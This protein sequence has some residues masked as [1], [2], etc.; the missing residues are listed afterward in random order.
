[1]FYYYYG[2][3]ALDTGLVNL[4]DLSWFMFRVI[5]WPDMETYLNWYTEE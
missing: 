2:D 3:I 4:N 5:Y 1:M